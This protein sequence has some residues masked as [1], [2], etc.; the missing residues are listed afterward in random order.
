LADHLVVCI[1]CPKGCMLRISLEAGEVKVYGNECPL[2][3]AFGKA[4]AENPH[5][6]VSSTVKVRGACISRLPV[7]TEK[8]VPKAKIR[9]V[10]KSLRGIV[11]EAPVRRGQVIVDNVAGTGVNVI[12]E[13]SLERCNG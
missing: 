8:P 5:R 11:V 10:I 2:G 13:R 4:E 7:R 12:A 1:R 3:E 9:E 6:I